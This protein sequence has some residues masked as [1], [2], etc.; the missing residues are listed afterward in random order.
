[1]T[2]VNSIYEIL[3]G[4]ATN[5]H[6]YH[7]EHIWLCPIVLHTIR[8]IRMLGLSRFWMVLVLS[9]LVRSGYVPANLVFDI[10]QPYNS[11]AFTCIHRL[12]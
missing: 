11:T 9:P 3:E 8:M 10:Y 6:L 5:R 4:F 12:I 7:I 1:M 2:Y